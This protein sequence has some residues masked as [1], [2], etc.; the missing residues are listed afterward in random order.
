MT[1]G[2][3]RGGLEQEPTGEFIEKYTGDGAREALVEAYPEPLTREE[4]AEA[5]GCGRTTAQTKLRELADA[6]DIRTK[7]VGAHAR[8]WWVTEET[9]RSRTAADE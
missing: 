1:D 7:K 4:V 5:V 9:W 6:G 3:I 2:E 8:I